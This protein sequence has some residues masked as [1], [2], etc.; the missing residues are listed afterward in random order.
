MS[1]WVDAN[2]WPVPPYLLLGCL[3]LEILYFRGWSI[4]L[5]GLQAKKAAG[6]LRTTGQ[7]G[8]TTGKVQWT[9]WHWRAIFFACALLTFL[10]TA[11]APIDILSAR[12]LWVHMVQHLLLIGVVAPLFI[13]AAP[14]LPFWLGLARWARRMLKVCVSVKIRRA[15]FRIGDWPLLPTVSCVLL[16]AGFWVW[17]WPP[18]Y[19]LALTNSAIHDWLEHTTF[20]AVSM[21]FWS[22]IILTPPFHARRGHLARLGYIGIAI[23]QNLMLAIILGFAQAPLYAPYAHLALGSSNFTALQDQRL[24][25]G[26]MWTFGDLPFGITFAVLVHQWLTLQLGKDGEVTLAEKQSA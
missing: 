22:Q 3:A 8:A 24:G 21:L 11:S 2:G 4:I 15:L 9:I 12:L 1:I 17:H 26:I 7:T 6:F 5:G 20:L 10:L 19:D 16:I 18:L 23:I 25:A 14:V 13:A